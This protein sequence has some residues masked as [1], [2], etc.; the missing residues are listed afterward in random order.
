[1]CL[2]TK[3][4]CGWVQA[5]G[6]R[7]LPHWCSLRRVLNAL[8]V[9]AWLVVGATFWLTAPTDIQIR[10]SVIACYGALAIGVIAV[11]AWTSHS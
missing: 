5:L 3:R 9:V 8:L 6:T 11:A 10:A 1:M 7:L 4:R 2:R